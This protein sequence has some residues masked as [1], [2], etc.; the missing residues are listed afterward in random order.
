MYIFVILS[1]IITVAA[2]IHVHAAYSRYS[3]V[4]NERGI[5]GAE[6]ARQLLLDH[7]ITNV[8]IE[9]IPGKLT[10]YYDP[11]RNVICL[12]EG[13]YDQDSVA[14]V[15]IAMHEAGHAVQYAQNYAPAKLRN[16]I[17]K[18]TNISST[19]S[20]LLV[21]AGI[22]LGG[23]SGR[24]G[25]SLITLGIYF[26]LA[27]IFFQLVTLPVEFNASGRAVRSLRDST[28]LN[29]D[30]QKGVRKVLSAAALTYVA[31]VAVSLLQLLRLLAIRGR[32]R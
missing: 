11:T 15:G 22:L 3:K 20:Y 8:G 21:V 17:V 23:G 29:S 18:S 26:F 6:A 2:Q 14:A 32:R 10:D 7:G 16:A 4:R 13:V 1:L 30:E 24:V 31:A 5:T 28:M 9:Q 25:Y 12:S 27:V 19:V